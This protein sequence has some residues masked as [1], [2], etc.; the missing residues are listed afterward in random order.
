MKAIQQTAR[1]GANRGE[2]IEMQTKS[3][4]EM[5]KAELLEATKPLGITH[6][7]QRSKEYLIR[8][9]KN[10]DEGS[11][12]IHQTADGKPAATVQVDGSGRTSAGCTIE[13]ASDRK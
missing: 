3:Y 10:W 8:A 2:G 4:H 11:P 6:A 1:S 12:I 13:S 5:T 7:R 9:L